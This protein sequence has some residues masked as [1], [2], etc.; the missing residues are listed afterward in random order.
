M[1]L[2]TTLPV[3]LIQ[4]KAVIDQGPG[5]LLRDRQDRLDPLGLGRRAAGGRVGREIADGEDA[6]LHDCPQGG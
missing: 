1:T 4:E 2:R 5:L 3:A 6:E